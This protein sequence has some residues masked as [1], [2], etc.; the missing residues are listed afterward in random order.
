MKDFIEELLYMCKSSKARGFYI[1]VTIALVALLLLSIVSLVLL[2]VN[3][4][5]FHTVAPLWIILLVVS[6][7]I[8][9]G[10]IIWLKKS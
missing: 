9:I 10:M 7:I 8:F 4:I 3:I 2:I 6:L 1:F 5:R